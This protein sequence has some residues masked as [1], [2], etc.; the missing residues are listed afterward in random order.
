MPFLNLRQQK[1]KNPAEV[2]AF[3]LSQT[4]AQRQ[5]FAGIIDCDNRFVEVVP[6]QTR[7]GAMGGAGLSSGKRWLK[8]WTQNGHIEK[9]TRKTHQKTRYKTCRYALNPIYRSSQVRALLTEIPEFALVFKMSPIKKQVVAPFYGRPKHNINILLSE[10]KRNIQ[11]TKFIDNE[12][13]GLAINKSFLLGISK[14]LNSTGFEASQTC[15]VE[16]PPKVAELPGYDPNMT[17]EQKKA[18]VLARSASIALQK[19][20]QQ[21]TP[22]QQTMPKGLSSYE[23]GQW[24]KAH[25]T[26]EQRAASEKL[27]RERLESQR[28]YAADFEQWREKER[29]RE[30]NELMRIY[31]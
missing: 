13:Y 31:H 2:K 14:Q 1:F 11:D 21:T 8:K 25:Y 30:Y 28:E 23:Q 3:W 29:R 17:P 15:Q 27:S 18:Y 12:N 5:S 26:S 7:I 10:T 16:N 24:L 19:K 6:S 4:K 20:E 22:I 9:Q